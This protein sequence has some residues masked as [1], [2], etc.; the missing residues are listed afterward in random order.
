MSEAS[1]GE[2]PPLHCGTLVYRAVRRSWLDPDAE[3]GALLP[4]AFLR[5]RPSDEQGLSVA[6]SLDEARA[7][8]SNPAAVVSLHVGRIRDLGLDVIADPLPQVP[9]STHAVLVNLPQ[10]DG[11][12]RYRARWLAGRLARMSRVVWRSGQ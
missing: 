7:A 10:G 11:P 4:D 3:G 8:L 12:E 5:V 2:R 1:G 6:G 9:G